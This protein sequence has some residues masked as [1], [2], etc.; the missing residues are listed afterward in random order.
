MLLVPYMW[1][2]M[3]FLPSSQSR[4]TNARTSAKSPSVFKCDAH[5]YNGGAAVETIEFFCRRHYRVIGC[6]RKFDVHN[7][8]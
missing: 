2:S 4:K 1:A 6:P 8:Y 3:T 7:K 5:V